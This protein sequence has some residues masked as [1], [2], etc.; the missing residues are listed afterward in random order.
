MVRS[1]SD[2]RP[3]VLLLAKEVQRKDSRQREEAVQAMQLFASPQELNSALR[4][5]AT[6]DDAEVRRWAASH[7]EHIDPDL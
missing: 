5:A 2:L 3:F 4:S 1:A 7:L 6:S